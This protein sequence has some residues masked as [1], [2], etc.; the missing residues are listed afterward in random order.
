MKSI[1]D[2]FDLWGSLSDMASDIKEPY[3][4]VSKWSQRGSIPVAAW[5]AVIGAAKKK[6]ASLSAD[7]LLLMHST[8]RAG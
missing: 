6:G 5:G 3:W 8:K 2:V 1:S 4:N 7:D